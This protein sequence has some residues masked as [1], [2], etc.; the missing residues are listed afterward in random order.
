M[1][2]LYGIYLHLGQAL[3]RMSSLLQ[4]E[5]MENFA[6]IYTKQKGKK[7]DWQYSSLSGTGFH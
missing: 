5:T 4:K 7:M 3:E 6:S 2:L 1:E